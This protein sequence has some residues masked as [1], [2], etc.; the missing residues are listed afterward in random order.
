M[1]RR[2]LVSSLA[3]LPLLNLPPAHNRL[4]GM[5]AAAEPGSTI[6]LPAGE[7]GVFGELRLGVPGVTLRASHPNRAILRAPLVIE[8]A[9][10][11][12]LGIAFDDPGDLLLAALACADSLTIRAPDVEVAG[13][14]FANFPAR[15]ILVR[16]EGLRPF[17]HDNT[18]HDNRT[19]S[20]DANAHEAISLG[21]DNRT[22]NTS[23]QARVLAN[24]MWNLNV[25]G[26]AISVKTS[27]NKL[28]LNQIHSSR[29]AFSARCGERNL[30]GGNLS[31]NAGGFTIE[32]RGNRFIGNRIEGT[33]M[34]KVMAGQIAAHVTDSNAHI[35]ATDT[36]LEICEGP[37]TV[38]Y[39][40][41]GMTPILP[42]LRTVLQSHKGQVTLRHQQGTVQR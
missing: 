2:D 27:D 29:A 3:A 31:V 40:Y 13:C 34:I 8:G 41:S 28:E 23:L 37:I 18:F 10:C 21:Y 26:E 39:A 7:Y 17:L 25:E 19:G 6:V 12:V 22:S 32:D 1:R 33:G 11:R 16:P 14:D 30:F 5:L 35:Q 15:A 36:Y 9:G 24:R 38:G 20:G 42:A 4:A